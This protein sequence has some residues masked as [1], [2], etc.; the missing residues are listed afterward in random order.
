MLDGD[1]QSCEKAVVFNT[2]QLYT[3]GCL[4]YLME[5]HQQAAKHAGKSQAFGGCRVAEQREV[6]HGRQ[7][8]QQR[9]KTRQHKA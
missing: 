1:I 4:Q 6:S 9:A 2:F 8:E 5:A 7:V 3:K